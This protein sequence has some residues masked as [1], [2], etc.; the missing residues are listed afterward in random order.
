MKGA[1][2][3]H[4]HPSNSTFSGADISILT[5]QG[6]ESIRAT[7]RKC[8]YHLTEIKGNFPRKEFAKAF[9]EAYNRNKKE[10]DK[11]YQRIK[12]N[13]NIQIQNGFKKRVIILMQD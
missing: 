12:K 11:E 6:L 8:T 13:T 5:C 10:T 7:G 9:T 2:L 1:N 3:T 4:N